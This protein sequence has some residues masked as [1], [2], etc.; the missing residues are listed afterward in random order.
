MNPP[1]DL[2]SNIE[3]DET[4]MPQAASGV[5]LPELN[6]PVR[7]AP[8]SKLKPNQLAKYKQRVWLVLED[9]DNIPPTGQFIGHNGTG[10][11]L[12]AGVPAEVPVEVLEILNN[13]EYLAP[14]VD[15][16]TKQVIDYKP[17]L[18]FPYRLVNAPREEAA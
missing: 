5:P 2:G 13:A 17:R 18:R 8:K 16:V 12:K 4:I 3:S 10:F 1:V 14:V 9:N 15:Q 11:M 6:V 7:E